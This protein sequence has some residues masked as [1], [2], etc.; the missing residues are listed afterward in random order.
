MP[1]YVIRNQN[2]RD[3]V[4]QV[5]YPFDAFFTGE[6]DDINIDNDIFLDAHFYFKT[7]TEL[8]I[9]ITEIDGTFGDEDVIRLRVSDAGGNNAGVCVFQSGDIRAAFFNSKGVDIGTVVMDSLGSVVLHTI[10]T[11]NIAEYQTLGLFYMPLY[12]CRFYLGIYN[13]RVRSLREPVRLIDQHAG[14]IAPAG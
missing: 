13:F 5:P 6:V 2:F 8:P 10:A 12:S 3:Q 7:P 1:N 9:S 14:Y 4:L 11:G